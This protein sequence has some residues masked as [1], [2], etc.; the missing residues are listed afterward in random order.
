MKIQVECNLCHHIIPM[1]FEPFGSITESFVRAKFV[2]DACGPQ[3]VTTGGRG[4][5]PCARQGVKAP[6]RS[7]HKND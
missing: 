7:P 4:V 5:D 6:Y 3:P 2:C 1:E